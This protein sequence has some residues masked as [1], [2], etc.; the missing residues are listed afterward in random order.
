MIP[1]PV[2]RLDLH[3]SRDPGEGRDPEAAKPPAC[4]SGRC[5][6]ASVASG[7]VSS[8]AAPG[9]PDPD[10][11][12]PA[13]PDG[14]AA[15][16]LADLDEAQ[17]HA[18]TTPAAPL[19]I[20]AG[21]GSGKTRVLTRRIAYRIATADCEARFSVAVTF[22]QRAAAELRGR[23]GELG[24][25]DRVAVGTF[26]GL[27]ARQL[28]RHAEDDGRSVPDILADPS[29]LLGDLLRGGESPQAAQAE[30]DW[31]AAQSVRPADYAGAAAEAGRRPPLAPGRLAELL[32]AYERKKRRL[33]LV[34]FGDL[35]RLAAERLENDA[36]TAEAWRWGRRHFF[37]DELQDLNP[38][39][40]RLL[41]AWLGDRSDLCAV[42]DPD[43]A[44]FGWSGADRRILDDFA[45][46]FAGATVVDLRQN[47]RCTPPI[48]ALSAVLRDEGTPSGAA[49][50]PAAAPD[51][52]TTP[53]P[54]IVAYPDE[55]AEAAGVAGAVRGARAPGDRWSAQAVL[56]RTRR[57]VAAVAGAL[58]AAGVP[59][60]VSDPDAAATPG[61]PDAV[62]VSTMHA[63]KGLEWP[64]VHVPG[65]EEGL[66][67]IAGAGRGRSLDEE[68]RLLYVALTRA[69]RHVHLSWAQQRDTPGQ[70]GERRPC[71]WLAALA[72]AGEPDPPGTS[73]WQGSRPAGRPPPD[74]GSPAEPLIAA[75]SA[76]REQVARVARVAPPAV[77]SDTDLAAIAESRP[78][79]VAELGI[80]TD[81][82]ASRL[83]RLGPELL[84]VVAEHAGDEGAP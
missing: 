41:R 48:V 68:R 65:L 20:R 81:L 64:V 73:R 42:G 37:V 28:R 6:S 4:T 49:A 40:L 17:R 58:E 74:M 79:T 71:R 23:L 11:R 2:R 62:C 43:Q 9:L 75:L 30:L 36:A 25:R 84:A 51:P 78:A 21:P 46:L 31:C 66:V 72:E 10:D 38:A 50:R 82:G 22:T 55:A 57:Q 61:D 15:H 39:Q 70:P 18:V 5:L 29:R 34:D 53:A 13:G 83:N 27:A 26:H 59:V 16:L 47:Y 44:I 67:P 8:G 52:F 80:I 76:W 45:E 60:H 24:I 56:V 1:A 3:T 14:D 69:R 32:V 7:I 63:A 33:G 35:L 77:L 12:D 54:L 19:C